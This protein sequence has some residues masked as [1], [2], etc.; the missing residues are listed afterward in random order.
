MY[1]NL[2]QIINEL[3]LKYKC[4]IRKYLNDI[5]LYNDVYSYDYVMIFIT[6]IIYVKNNFHFNIYGINNH[7]ILI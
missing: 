7:Y 4:I 3:I 2:S 5:I 6:D 1:L